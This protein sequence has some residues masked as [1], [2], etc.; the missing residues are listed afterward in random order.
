MREIRL[1]GAFM[2]LPETPR[3]K[4]ALWQTSV[5]F[6]ALRAFLVFSD[7]YNPGNVTIRLAEKF[8]A[9]FLQKNHDDLVDQVDQE[10][11]EVQMED[12]LTISKSRGVSVAETESW[13]TAIYHFK[14]YLAGLMSLRMVWRWFERDEIRDCMATIWDFTKEKAR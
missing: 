1:V 10:V 8:R 6:T 7:R 4:R 12:E 3:S 14:W 2:E 9:V 5:Y 13:V 11:P